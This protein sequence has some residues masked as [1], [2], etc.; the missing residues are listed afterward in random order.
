M[1]ATNNSTMA[2]YAQKYLDRFFVPVSVC[3]WKTRTIAAGAVLRA[4]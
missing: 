2:G 1:T 3:P 4:A